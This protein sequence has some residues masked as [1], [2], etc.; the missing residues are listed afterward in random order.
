MDGPD[1]FG[2]SLGHL[3]RGSWVP[4]NLDLRIYGVRSKHSSGGVSDSLPCSPSFM[5]KPSLF[6]SK[7]AALGDY[8][9]H[10]TRKVEKARIDVKP[11]A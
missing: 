2:W 4:A 9:I 11:W 8:S 5:I 3:G 10:A 1:S 6:G 7:R